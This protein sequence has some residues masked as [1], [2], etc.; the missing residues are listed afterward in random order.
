MAR[1]KINLPDKFTF[2]TEI[3]IRIT[4][5]NYGGHA[6]N[7]TILSLI[8]EARMQFLMH[9]GFTELNIGGSGMIMSDVM[10]EFKSEV[11]YRD[12]IIASVTAGEFSKVS[13]ELFY[14]LEKRGEDN[15]PLPVAFAKTT[16]ISYDYEKKK[17]T[18]IPEAVSN[19]LFE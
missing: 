9:H 11:F 2:T 18:A 1:I 15:K 7:D 13:F 4:D 8:H 3:P 10:I 14:K 5:L 16:M 19:K 6:G 12:I 17:V